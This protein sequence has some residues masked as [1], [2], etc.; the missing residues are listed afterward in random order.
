MEQGE[1][2]S[3]SALLVRR[4]QCLL[5]L[6]GLVVTDN[7]A[8]GRSQH[9]MMAGDVSSDAADDG[10]F[11]AA[12]C[13]RGNSRGGNGEREC[14]AA[15]NRFHASCSVY[16]LFA[17]SCLAG[18]FRFRPI[19]E[20]AR[21]VRTRRLGPDRAACRSAGESG[22]IGSRARGASLATAGKTSGITPATG[23]ITDY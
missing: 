7:A 2:K 1:A 15:Q 3:L 13:I 19:A 8:C 23:A 18:L 22:S 17:N 4:L 14:G 20:S 12:F 5:A 21:I 10:A 16:F 11:D 6:L 9:A